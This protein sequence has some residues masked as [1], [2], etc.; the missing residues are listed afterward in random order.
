MNVLFLNTLYQ[1]DLEEVYQNEMLQTEFKYY[2]H[3]IRDIYTST[4]DIAAQVNKM[5]VRLR[6]EMQI[7][8][9]MKS[10]RSAC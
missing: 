8:D 6:S 2:R 1:P 4:Y 9:E 3:R 10:D 5:V 7:V